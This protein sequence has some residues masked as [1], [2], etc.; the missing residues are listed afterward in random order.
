MA[1][2]NPAPGVRKL[3]A[4]QAVRVVLAALAFISF[5]IGGALLSW[6]VLPLASCDWDRVRRQRRCQRLVQATFVLFHDYMRITGLVAFDPRRAPQPL[7]EGAFVLVTNHP[8]LIDV[9]ALLA[10]YGE[11]CVVAKSSLFINPLIG[12]LLRLCGHIESSKAEFGAQSS[13]VAQ[14]VERLARG[15][16]VLMFPEGSRSPEVGL[17]RFHA[18]AFTTAVTGGAP[19]LPGIIRAQ[20][21]GL[22]KGQ[23][24]Y[25]IP[26]RPM[27]WSLTLL[28]PI[29]TSPATSTRELMSLARARI[30]AGLEL[31][32]RLVGERAVE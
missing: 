26:T 25:D 17:R 30:E 20:P 7:P 13:V 18:G 21:P 16:R 9:T 15:Q 22:K 14:A 5:G 8:T 32:D 29:E 2:P 27:E 31:D 23:A 19:I 24:W 3:T 12:V 4:R 28:A 1:T 11:L 6:L 10:A